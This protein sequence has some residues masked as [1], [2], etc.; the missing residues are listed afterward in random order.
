MKY[1]LNVFG[2][3]FQTHLVDLFKVILKKN[4]MNYRQKCL[5]IVGV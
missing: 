4:Q 5:I 1:Y 3:A 2:L